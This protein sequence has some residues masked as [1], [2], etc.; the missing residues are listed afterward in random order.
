MDFTRATKLISFVN[1]LM[2]NGLRKSTN[3]KLN[4]PQLDDAPKTL[5]VSLNYAY[6]VT[7]ILTQKNPNCS[8]EVVNN[9]TS[10]G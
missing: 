1:V 7:A 6:D 5:E 8:T 3:C 4:H 2:E 9:S 10:K